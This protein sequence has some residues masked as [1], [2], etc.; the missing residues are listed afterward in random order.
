MTTMA[1][2]MAIIRDIGELQ[3]IVEVG[4][5][6]AGGWPVWAAAGGVGLAAAVAIVS[7]RRVAMLG[8]RGRIAL[9]GARGVV[10]AA[11][12]LA[13]FEPVLRVE[14]DV[15]ERRVAAILVDRSRSMAIAELRTTRAELRAAATALGAVDADSP[16][17]PLPAAVRARVRRVSRQGIAE[18]L[19]DGPASGWLGQLAAG[20]R[21][22]GYGFGDALIDPPPG[23]LPEGDGVDEAAAVRRVVESEPGADRSAVGGAIHAAIERHADDLLAGLVVITDGASNTGV[24]LRD[25]GRRAAAQGVPIFPVVIGADDPPDLAVAGVWTRE[26]AYPGEPLRVVVELKSVG[27]EGERARLTLRFDGEV[28]ADSRVALADGA[29][30]H[31]LTF[32]PGA[33]QLGPRPLSVEVEPLKGEAT[34]ENNRRAMTVRVVDQ[35]IR[36]LYIERSPRLEYRFIKRVLDGDRRIEARY[37]LQSADPGLAARAERFIAEPPRDEEGLRGYDVVIL[38]DVPP[39]SLGEG[40]GE[41]LAGW[42][43]RRGGALLVVAGERHMPGGFAGAPLAGAFAVRLGAVDATATPSTDSFARVTRAGRSAWPIA[44]HHDRSVNASIWKAAAPRRPMPVVNGVRPGAETLVELAAPNGVFEGGARG[45]SDRR[46][47]L[48]VQRRIGSGRSVYIG[49]DELWRMRRVGGR[50]DYHGRF[51]RQLVRSASEGRVLRGSERVTVETDRLNYGVD[52]AVGLRAS[53]FDGAGEPL[54]AEA[55]RLRIEGGEA[56]A[57]DA[58]GAGDAGGGASTPIGAAALSESATRGG[59]G[60]GELVVL[61]RAAEETGVYE[62]RYVPRSAGRYTVRAVEAEAR[63]ANVASFYVHDASVEALEPGAAVEA[64]R[65]LAE[66]TG[67]RLLRA[68]EAGRLPGLLASSRGPVRRVYRVTLAD[69]PLTYG[70]IAIVLGVEWFTRRR[71]ELV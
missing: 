40:F 67:G 48:I 29:R 3:R 55:Y 16:E 36:V 5:V 28:V 11:I 6:L 26:A 34:V 27:F 32:E 13:L 49:S 42:V 50:V 39:G 9:A 56:G 57:S 61:H 14:A 69:S 54:E 47:A 65:A 33:G 51:W 17:G 63:S 43:R 25:A 1:S 21:L 64:L 19:V 66:A 58:S 31:A 52:E 38:G 22:V 12:V 30:R 24:S 53:V 44:L 2:G 62:G 59:A 71:R 37:L 20:H 18:A 7:Y 46:A 15:R 45:R 10:L 23:S 41:R 4:L 35:T 70:L 8:R 68:D 60:A